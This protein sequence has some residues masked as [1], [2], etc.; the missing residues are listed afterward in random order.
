M[1]GMFCF[2]EGGA[3]KYD[4]GLYLHIMK[5]VSVIYNYS[6]YMLRLKR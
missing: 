2:V 1:K 4:I 3:D 5:V 6:S